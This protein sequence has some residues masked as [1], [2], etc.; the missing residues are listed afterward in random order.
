MSSHVAFVK[1]LRGD[2]RG[3][4]VSVHAESG[5]LLVST[6]RRGACV[7]TVHL[8][9]NEAAHL[10]AALAAGVAEPAHPGHTAKPSSKVSDARTRGERRSSWKAV[11][12]RSAVAAFAAVGAFAVLQWPE[13]VGLTATQASPVAPAGPAHS[14][15][16]QPSMRRSIERAIDAA[17]A[18]GVE[19]R[20]TSGARTAERQ[21]KLFDGA[22]AKHGSSQ[23][24][25]RWVLPPQES[26]HV[27]GQAVDVGP[28]VAAAWLAE[29]GDGFG[30]C[31]RY[32][33]EP[34]HFERLAGAKGSLC[35]AL[36]P[37]P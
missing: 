37:H 16:L 5:F 1:D 32:A 24:A 21:Q 15:G 9:P 6:W 3:L 17:A 30:L 26:E 23:A 25:R 4:S 2:G 19:L 12:V 28:P 20:I 22:V 27:A 7:S 29:N 11:G 14:V 31:Q 13:Q 33:N 36:Q 8:L 10:G 18:E 35:P 34:W